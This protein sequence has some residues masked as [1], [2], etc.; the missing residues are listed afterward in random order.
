MWTRAELKERA[1][2]NLHKNYWMVVAVTFI[3][4]IASGGVNFGANIPITGGSGSSNHSS[5]S[6]WESDEDSGIYDSYDS[7]DD[8]EEE[9]SSTD[10]GDKRTWLIFGGFAAAFFAII[11]AIAMA[12]A[13]FVLNPL[14]V[15]CLKWYIQNRKENPQ[16]GIVGD[17]FKYN[18]L[19][20][21]QTLF[22]QMLFNF[23]WFMLFIIPGIVKAYE[24]RM[25]PYI[26]AEN[27]DIT[28]EEAFRMSKEMMMGEKMNAFILDL[29][30]ILWNMLTLCCCGIVGFF[31]V[32]PYKQLTNVELYVKLKEI[33]LGIRDD[34]D[35]FGKDDY[36]SNSGD[37]YQ[38]V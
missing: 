32:Y 33:H 26:V 28:R 21:V 13:V 9:V 31:Y 23:L 5:V 35:P 8:D 14:K 38:E 1:K 30:F 4:M 19:K 3:V 6:S 29:S 24:Y 22:C 27:P 10:W 18:Y 11:F 16:F 17:G 12:I 7:Y 37:G 25:I 36:Y 34:A 2:Q 15:G 20:T